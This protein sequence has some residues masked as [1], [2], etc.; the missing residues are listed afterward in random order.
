LQYPPVIKPLGSPFIELQSIDSTN[1]YALSR[2]RERLADHGMVFFAH[3]Q[4]AGKGQ[5]GKRWVSEK[6]ANIAMSI[7]LRPEPLLVSQQFILSACIAV[8]ALNFLT[9]YAGSDV[10]VKWPNDIYWQERKLGGILIENIV[11]SDSGSS[12]HWQW[13]V[14][15][16]G[17]NVN[18]T[19]FP[20]DLP[21]PVSLK[22]ITGKEFNAVLLAKD[23]CNEIGSYFTKLVQNGFDEVY[24]LYN[25]RIYKLNE[26][27]K[28][29]K[30]N[31]VFQTTIKGV[32]ET[33][34][35]ITH[36]SVLEERFVFGEVTWLL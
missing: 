24:K 4:T 21:N 33:G 23:L 34:E 18:Q 13:A 3:E 25:E 19:S 6:G 14:A 1:N 20:P 15:G 32:S 28:L 10:R 35:L 22:Q 26:P 36:N 9:P 5:M 27:V 29:K 17:I 12:S 2:I 8:A 30:H 31:T 11:S 16:I 7:V